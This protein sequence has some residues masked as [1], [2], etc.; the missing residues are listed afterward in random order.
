MKNHTSEISYI[1]ITHNPIRVKPLKKPNSTFLFGLV[2]PPNVGY[3]LLILAI[4]T[5]LSVFWIEFSPIF[6]CTSIHHRQTVEKSRDNGLVQLSYVNVSNKKEELPQQQHIANVSNIKVEFGQQNHFMNVSNDE[7]FWKQ[8][9]ALGYRPCLEFSDEYIRRVPSNSGN[10]ERRRRFLMVVVSGGLNQQKI[11]IA[12]AVVV[13]RIVEATLV[14]P[15]LHVDPVWGD[16]SEFSD[17]FDEGHFK[18]TLK[19]DVRVVSTLP[20]SLLRRR[21]MPISVVP[22]LVHEDWIRTHLVGPLNRNGIVILRAFDSKLSKDLSSD[23]QKLRCKVAFHA[24][25]FRTWIEELGEKL[26]KRMAHR[27]PYMALHLRLEKDVWVRT[28]CLPGLGKKADQ[29]IESERALHPELLKSRTNISARDRYIAGLCPLNAVEI[30]RYVYIY[31]ILL[32]VRRNEWV[33]RTKSEEE[34]YAKTIE[35]RISNNWLGGGSEKVG[36]HRKENKKR[37]E[38]GGRGG[39]W[40]REGSPDKIGRRRNRSDCGGKN[41]R[42][43]GSIMEEETEK[44]ADNSRPWTWHGA[45]VRIRDIGAE[46]PGHGMVL[47]SKSKTRG[48]IIVVPGLGMVRPNRIK[49]IGAEVPGC[50]MVRQSES[51]TRGQI[52]VVPGLGMGGGPRAWHGTPSQIKDRGQI[53]V[54]PGLGMMARS[55]Q[56]YRAKVP[57][58]G[59]VCASPNQRLRAD[60]S[61]PRTRHGTPV[62]IKDS[63]ADN[64]CPRTRHGTLV[65]IKDIGAEVPGCGMV[66]QFESKTWGHI[67]V[68]PGLGMVRQ[69]ESKLGADIRCSRTR[70]G[71]LV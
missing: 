26:A 55:N 2:K 31:I 17:I 32:S 5:S 19:N 22:E 44:G 61:C 12:D 51:K 7:E 60:N 30:T 56:R 35:W 46:V 27:G 15:I 45:P 70:H 33:I 63:G 11:Q 14:V 71:M 66:R 13:A 29:V 1:R 52:I 10:K 58:R 6:S 48:Q 39:R 68:V 59:M 34:E 65:R 18:E 38:D 57:G 53:I 62:Q 28:G 23:L 50:G 69:T 8:P 37:N 47:Q 9:D 16:E 41:E 20:A 36:H 21:P 42:D 24:L 54:V 43:G 67:I 25:K 64:S 3:I 40:R 49:D 4:G